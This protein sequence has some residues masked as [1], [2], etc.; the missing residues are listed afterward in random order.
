MVINLMTEVLQ[1]S[2]RGSPLAIDHL[3][4]DHVFGRG[5]ELHHI[6]DRSLESG[7]LGQKDQ[8]SIDFVSAEAFVTETDPLVLEQ[9]LL[10]A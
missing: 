7:K 8:V 1:Q 10:E 4:D 3:V 6:P 2:N 5:R 9:A